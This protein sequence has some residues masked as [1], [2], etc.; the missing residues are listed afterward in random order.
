MSLILMLLFP[1]ISSYREVIWEPAAASPAEQR[2]APHMFR[3][4][5]QSTSSQGNKSQTK[6]TEITA[7]ARNV[8]CYYTCIQPLKLFLGNRANLK[9]KTWNFK[10][11]SPVQGVFKE[12][13]H[14]EHWFYPISLQGEFGILIQPPAPSITTVSNKTSL[15][16]YNCVNSFCYVEL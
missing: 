9:L 6:P 1:F 12:N 5:V 13:V 15:Q 14:V 7:G 11:Q 10:L 2:W 8:S 16:L 4:T 3:L